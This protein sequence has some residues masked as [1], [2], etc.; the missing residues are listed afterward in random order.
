M[1]CTERGILYTSK[2][3]NAENTMMRTLLFIA[4][5][6]SSE[7]TTAR[8]I[9]LHA[10]RARHCAACKRRRVSSKGSRRRTPDASGGP[11]LGPEIA[12]SRLGDR[13]LGLER[14]STSC[15]RVRRGGR[16]ARVAFAQARAL[17]PGLQ[18]LRRVDQRDGLARVLLG[19]ALGGGRQRAHP[20]SQRTQVGHPAKCVR[21]ER[22]EGPAHRNQ[23]VRLGDEVSVP[24]EYVA[25]RV[26]ES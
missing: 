24:E 19:N 22:C 6:L 10:A 2:M 21:H 17:L 4:P 23:V 18:R 9:A 1:G 8:S 14:R 11:D 12:P 13:N 20:L 15:H 7:P 3:H 16:A 25:D 5:Q 26:A